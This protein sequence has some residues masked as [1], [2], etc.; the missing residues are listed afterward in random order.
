MIHEQQIVE[1][2]RQV[3]AE[4]WGE[5]LHFLETLRAAPSSKAEKPIRTASDLANS[6]LVGFWADRT[7]IGDN[8]TLARRLRRQAEQRRVR[9]SPPREV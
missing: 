9:Q 1:T 6:G 2:L 3:P 5:V 7:D 4:R 8:H